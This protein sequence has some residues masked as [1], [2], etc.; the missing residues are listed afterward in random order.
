MTPQIYLVE[1]VLG[2]YQDAF[3]FAIHGIGKQA[4][5]N[6]RAP[7]FSASYRGMEQECELADG[8]ALVIGDAHELRRD[9]VE[10]LTHAYGRHQF[11]LVLLAPTCPCGMHGTTGRCICSDALRAVFDRRKAHLALSF[12]T[13]WVRWAD[14]RKAARGEAVPS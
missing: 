11:H 13:S 8:A 5:D 12:N 4:G 10:L 1:H 3:R 6:V 9:V 2:E 7:H 14:L